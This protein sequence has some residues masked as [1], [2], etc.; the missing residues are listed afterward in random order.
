MTMAC[1]SC[2]GHLRMIT[3]NTIEIDVCDRCDAIWLD[4]GELNAITEPA[5]TPLG[6]P[7]MT[8][9]DAPD[10]TCPRCHTSDFCDMA[11]DAVSVSRCNGCGGVYVGVDELDRLSEGNTQIEI[12]PSIKNIPVGALDVAVRQKDERGPR[13]FSHVIADGVLEMLVNAIFHF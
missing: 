7:V 5:E 6:Q 11:F 8:L 9:R 4:P 13:P 12:D 2:S 10:L 1:P 3:E